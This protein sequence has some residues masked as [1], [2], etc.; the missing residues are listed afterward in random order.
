VLDQILR[1]VD[2]K[3]EALELIKALDNYPNVVRSIKGEIDPSLLT[4]EDLIISTKLDTLDDTTLKILV[5]YYK[6]V[7]PEFGDIAAEGNLEQSRLE[8]IVIPPESAPTEEEAVK[9]TYK[10]SDDYVE[11]GKN[12]YESIIDDPLRGNYESLKEYLN[13]YN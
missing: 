10:Q 8:D 1:T 3:P 2:E 13:K 7:K 5:D 9:F 11:R 12:V 6:K 4:K